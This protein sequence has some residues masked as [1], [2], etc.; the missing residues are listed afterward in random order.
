M[1]YAQLKSRE[2]SGSG[3]TLT[4][5][6]LLMPQFIIRD[7]HGRFHISLLLGGSQEGGTQAE[8][9][10]GVMR[11]FRGELAHFSECLRWDWITSFPLRLMIRVL[12][13]KW[14]R[15]HLLGFLHLTQYLI[16]RY[17]CKI[18][19]FQIWV[20]VILGRC[21]LWE[22]ETFIIIPMTG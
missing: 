18:F 7:S 19:F 3:D 15:E 17:K 16:C 9:I 2:V 11:L 6:S 13:Q 22:K 1:N 12:V 4:H 14:S 8:S 10:G 21:R 20:Q 5:H